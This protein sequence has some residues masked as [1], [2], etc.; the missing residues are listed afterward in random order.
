MA[1][2]SAR[3]LFSGIHNPLSTSSGTAA[4]FSGTRRLCQDPPWPFVVCARQNR[5]RQSA[6]SDIGNLCNAHALGHIWLFPPPLARLPISAVFLQPARPG[7]RNESTPLQ[8]LRLSSRARV[9]GASF[10]FHL[11][12]RTLLQTCGATRPP[13]RPLTPSRSPENW[14]RP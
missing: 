12:A 9:L 14:A 10:G 13:T 11:P 2:K 7:D 3:P 6:L 1:L 5:Q 4:S 8:D